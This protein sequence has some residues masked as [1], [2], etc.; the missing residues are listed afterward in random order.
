MD[1]CLYAKNHGLPAADVAAAL[2]RTPVQ[3]ERVFRDID[4]KRKMARY[5]HS[6]PITLP[7]SK[8]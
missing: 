5:L 6:P 1:L 4:A 2:E 3:I 7:H 8:V